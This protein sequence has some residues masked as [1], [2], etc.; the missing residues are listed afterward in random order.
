MRKIRDP[1][2]WAWMQ[3]FSLLCCSCLYVLCSSSDIPYGKYSKTISRGSEDVNY[4][5]ICQE[6]HY[7]NHSRIPR[8]G[9]L[10]RRNGRGI[11]LRTGEGTP[12][13]LLFSSTACSNACLW[14]GTYRRPASIPLLSWSSNTQKFSRK[15]DLSPYLSGSSRRV[16]FKIIYQHV[17]KRKQNEKCS[18]RINQIGDWSKVNS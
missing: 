2:L 9:Q 12:G 13:M 10:L 7:L 18:N 15:L 16:F 1:L 3:D 17:G 11:V 14:L 6:N 8:G 5:I 4:L